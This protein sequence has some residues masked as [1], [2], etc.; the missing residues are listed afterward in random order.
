[1]EYLTACI[2]KVSEVFVS[3]VVA[4]VL[5]VLKYIITDPFM[6]LLVIL[7]I[8]LLFVL[9]YVVQFAILIITMKSKID[10]VADNVATAHSWFKKFKSLKDTK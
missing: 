3:N 6:I 7:A 4:P 5:N 9:W 10:D 1:M 8:L 2:E